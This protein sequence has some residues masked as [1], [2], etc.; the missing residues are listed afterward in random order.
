MWNR[1]LL[2]TSAVVLACLSSS[3]WSLTLDQFQNKANYGFWFESGIVR[4]QEFTPTLSNVGAV[5]LWLERTGNPGN[6]IVEIR[7]PSG[8]TAGTAQIPW[9]QVP[10]SGWVMAVFTPA[11]PVTPG[12]KYRIYV[13]S[14]AASLSLAQRFYWRGS[15][16]STYN[17]A[18]KTDVSGGWPS[19][20]YAFR[21]WVE[22][23][24]ASANVPGGAG[25]FIGVWENNDANTGGMTRLI[26]GCEGCLMTVHGF[27]KCTPTDCDWGTIT[28]PYTGNPLVAV[29]KF[30]FKTETLTIHLTGP[31]ALQVHSVNVFH[32]GSKRDYVADYSLH[33]VNQPKDF[34]GVWENDDAKTGGMTRLILGCAGCALTVHGFGAC[35]PTDCDWGTITATYTGNPFVAVYEFGFKTETLTIE[36]T[37]PNALHVQSVNVFHDGS[38]RDYVA[39]YSLHRVNQPKDFVGTWANNDANT[40]GMTKLILG[41]DGCAMMVHGFGA[42]APADCDWGAI[43]AAY[44][45]NPFVAVYEFGFKTDTLTIQLT[46]PNALKVHSVNVF[47][48]GSKRDYVADYFLHRVSD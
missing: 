23:P 7:T 36:L 27:G 8:V 6:V 19:F 5:E 25:D 9:P 11:V 39:E 41:W 43:A 32:D 20:D 45:G 4:W 15:T 48:D 47:H 37:G 38:K 3:A 14:D 44:T 16:A 29:Y 22:T 2:I 13:R 33:R 1:R 30:G 17:P 12:Y 28:T 21:T 10:S 46:G 18:C 26:L 40:G 24:C 34:A 31:N 35:I 42:C